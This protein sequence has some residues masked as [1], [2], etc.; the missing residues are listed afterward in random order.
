PPPHVRRTKILIYVGDNAGEI[1]FDKIL[2]RELKKIGVREIFFVVKGG[3]ISNDVLLSDF[4]EVGLDDF[5]QVLTTGKDECGMIPE[6]GPP[7]LQE[8]WRRADLVISKGQ[9]NF[10]S[11]SGRKEKIYFL[12]KAKCVPVARE[13][14]VKQGALILKRNNSLM[15]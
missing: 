9:G 3:P 10:E 8:V 2:L 1:V 11:L 4:W 7:D 12:L 14:G 6:E 5:A 15:T 13:F